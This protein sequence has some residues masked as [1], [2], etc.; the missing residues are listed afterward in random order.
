MSDENV[1]EKHEA[2]TAEMLRRYQT[3]ESVLLPIPRDVFEKLYLSPKTPTAGN[4]RRT[5]GNPTPISLLGFLLAATPAAMI[6]MGWRG[7]GGNG[8]AILPVFIYFGGMV[9]IFGAVGEWIIGN[10]FSCALFFTY[11]TFWIVQGTS[12]MPF[13][14]V[15]TNYSPTGNS[16]EGIQTPEYNATVG[17]Y[18]VILSVLTFVYLICSIRTNICLFSALFLL[19]ITFALTAATFFQVALGNAENAAKL[20]LAAGAF[21]FALCI[22]IWH[23]FIAQILDAVDFP[24]TLPVGDLSTIVPGRSQKERK[25]QEE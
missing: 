18:Y 7:A 3:A 10:T 2:S 14:A 20:Q 13:Y 22:P 12:N 25:H 9:Q 6:N 11:G 15:G 8:G 4:L 23:I 21:N 1:S 24:I 19:V 17:L 16:L 5:F